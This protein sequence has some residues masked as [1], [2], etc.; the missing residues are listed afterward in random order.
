MNEGTS[1]FIMTVEEVSE[2]LR[3]APYFCANTAHFYSITQTQGISIRKF[4]PKCGA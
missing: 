1:D 2:Y 4:E 3:L